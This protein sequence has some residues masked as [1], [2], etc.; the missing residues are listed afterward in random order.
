MK[1]QNRTYALPADTLDR[2]ERAVERGRRSAVVGELIRGWLQDGEKEHLRQ[3]IIE[4]CRDMADVDRV[5]EREWHPL[6]EE[7][8]S[9][10]R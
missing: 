8:W 2:F 6:A 7:A 9:A 10:L 3:Q 1:R 4:G 5:T